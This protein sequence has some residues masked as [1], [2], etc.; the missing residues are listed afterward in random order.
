MPWTHT[1]E[2]F[3]YVGF[4]VS[5]GVILAGIMQGMQGPP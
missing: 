3:V 4:G 2:T 1:G 5:I